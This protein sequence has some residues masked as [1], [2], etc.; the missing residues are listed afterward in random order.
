MLTR[1]GV[2]NTKTGKSG[3]RDLRRSTKAGQGRAMVFQRE[4]KASLVDHGEVGVGVQ[5]RKE[6]QLRSLRRHVFGR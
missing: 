5:C 4:R 6:L 2:R 1:A 3:E